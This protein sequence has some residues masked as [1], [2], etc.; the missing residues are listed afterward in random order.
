MGSYRSRF[1]WQHGTVP[2][3][4]LRQVRFCSRPTRTAPRGENER[5]K[6][7]VGSQA[8]VDLLL[9]LFG[10]SSEI[11][12]DVLPVPL[13]LSLSSNSSISSKFRNDLKM[14]VELGSPSIVS[15]TV[16]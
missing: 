14:E 1:A 6:K 13:F 9:A 7:L 3:G 16:F 15:W 10:R 2:R 11:K 12:A 8:E 5:E 4:W